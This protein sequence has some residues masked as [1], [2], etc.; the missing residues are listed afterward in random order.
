MVECEMC[1]VHAA[2]DCTESSP[3]PT[4]Q[5]TETEQRMPSVP[6]N[7]IHK[8]IKRSREMAASHRIISH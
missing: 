3:S 2:T 5:R 7:A 1:G 6:F 4:Q 8:D